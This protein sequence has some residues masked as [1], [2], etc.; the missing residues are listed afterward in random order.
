ML[1][2]DVDRLR[3]G[4][5]ANHCLR[6]GRLLD[7]KGNWRARSR[8]RRPAS[9]TRPKRFTTIAGTPNPANPTHFS[10]DEAARGIP[11]SIQWLCG[12]HR[13]TLG[14]SLSPCCVSSAEGLPKSLL[15]AAAC[16]RWSATDVPGCGEVVRWEKPGCCDDTPAHLPLRFPVASASVHCHRTRRLEG[17]SRAA[18]EQQRHPCSTSN[19]RLTTQIPAA[20]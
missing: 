3:A 18:A 15:E 9:R 14:E 12:G 2:V 5:P 17:W 16:G 6:P 4:R 7:D 1:H 11:T 10:A 20:D 19:P 13:D 8:R